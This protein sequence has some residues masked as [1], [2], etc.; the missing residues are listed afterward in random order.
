MPE[1]ATN[2]SAEAGS[3]ANEDNK[4]VSTTAA[5]PHLSRDVSKDSVEKCLIAPDTTRLTILSAQEKR[6]QNTWEEPASKE[7]TFD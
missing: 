7:G 6:W 4:R 5:P 1:A 3:R 2:I